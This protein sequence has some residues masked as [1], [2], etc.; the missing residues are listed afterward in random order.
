MNK[1]LTGEGRVG[2][3]EGRGRRRARRGGGRGGERGGEEGMEGKE[4]RG[5]IPCLS[6]N[7]LILKM[8]RSDIVETCNFARRGKGMRCSTVPNFKSMP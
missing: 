4:V 6:T 7:L 1:K 3:G 8:Q 5:R 2:E